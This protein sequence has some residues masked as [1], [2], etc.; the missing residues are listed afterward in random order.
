M[1]TTAIFIVVLGGGSFVRDLWSQAKT[2]ERD[3]DKLCAISLR[4]PARA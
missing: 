3:S 4:A 2:G 1:F